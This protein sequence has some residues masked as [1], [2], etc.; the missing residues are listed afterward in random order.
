MEYVD[1]LS[2][3]PLSAW[4]ALLVHFVADKVV[5]HIMN[6]EERA[7]AAFGRARRHPGRDVKVGKPCPHACLVDAEDREILGLNGPLVACIRYGEGTA[8]DVVQSVGVVC[9]GR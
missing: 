4:N 2:S 5:A 8:R 3:P 9:S 6:P 7:E 1:A